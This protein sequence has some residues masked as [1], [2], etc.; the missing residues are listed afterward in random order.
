MS[1]PRFL[2][3]LFYPTVRK[4]A[5]MAAIL[6][7]LL[8]TSC[9]STTPKKA[10]SP[11]PPT[12]SSASQ[13]PDEICA[14]QGGTYLG[15][16]HCRLQTGFVAQML[17]GPDAARANASSVSVQMPHQAWALATTALIFAFNGNHLD[18]LTGVA[19]IPDSIENERKQ[20]AEGW[21]IYSQADLL[22]TLDWLQLQGHRTGFNELGLRVSTLSDEQLA[23]KR[24]QLSDNTEAVNQLDVVRAHYQE[25]GSKSILAWDLVRYISLCR[26]GVLAGYISEDYAW[27]R[28]MP[29]A[30]QLQQTFNSWQDLQTNY[31]I[32]RE[33]WSLK[34]TKKC[35]AKFQAIFKNL[36]EDPSSPWNRIPWNTPL[37][38]T[39]AMLT[40]TQ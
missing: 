3:G 15:D 9:V 26:W 2:L 35:G 20:L 11:T 19:A 39:S 18:T 21:S 34:Q 14:S 16:M 25:L 6:S 5:L 27:A 29:A 40:T 4:S 36:S 12:P 28:I 8:T 24:S 1:T 37:H 31:L 33:Y 32:G 10:P 17:S 38:V 30:Q 22:R 13:T 7:T 23:V